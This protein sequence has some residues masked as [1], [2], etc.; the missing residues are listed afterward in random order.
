M[1]RTIITILLAAVCSMTWAQNFSYGEKANPKNETIEVDHIGVKK[2]GKYMIPV[3]GE[4]HYSRVPVSEW[5]NEIAK[6]KAGGITLLSTYVFWNHHEDVEGQ[7]SWYGK[8]NLRQFIETC[9]EEEMPVVLRIGPFCHG[10]VY[11]GG[12]PEWL[13][14]K[15]QDNPSEYKL[16]STAPGFM[17]AATRLYEEIARQ[18]YGLMWK[19]GGPIVG[20]QIENECRGPWSYYMALRDVAIKVGFDVPFM[21]RTGWP[22]LNGKEEFGKLLPL[23]G[24]YA[25]G[26][27]DRQLT[28]MPGAYKEA[29]IMKD[30]RMSRVIATETFSAEEL[31]S[32]SSPLG[33]AGVGLYPYLTCEL[34]GG[35]MPSY[36]RRINM[37]GNEAMPLAICKLGSGSNLPGYYMYH[38]GTNPNHPR[39]TMAECQNSLVTN[40][41]DMPWKSYDFQCPLGEM[42]QPHWTVWNQTRWLH[43][44]LNDWGEELAP[45]PVEGLTK[46]YSRR[47]QFIFSNTYVRILNEEGVASVTPEGM[48]WNGLTISSESVQPFAKADGQLYFITVPGKEE[49]EIDVNGAKHTL[50]PDTQLNIEGKTLN[51]LSPKR[52]ELAYV[53]DGHMHFAK[54]NAMIY[55]CDGRLVEEQ[56][57]S[58]K[59][60]IGLRKI[61]TADTPRTVKLG[62]QKV[63]E[64]PSVEDFDHA[65][66]Y[67]ITLPSSLSN[68]ADD[69]FLEINYKGDCARLYVDGELVQDNFWNGK[70]MLVRVSDIIGRDAATR[71][72]GKANEMAN[73]MTMGGSHK[74]ELRILPLKSDY[75]IYLQSEQR[76]VLDKAKDGILL[77]LTGINLLTRTRKVK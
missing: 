9:K 4:I 30:D 77:E 19:D 52:A 31:Q 57:V 50:K 60:S 53:I 49:F 7:W 29:F 42:G 16:R 44:F 36:H 10:E 40:Y 61:K 59:A 15:A 1:R 56:W 12:M 37:S 8:N 75:P 66:I 6:M 23:Y 21:T 63:A 32:G 35:M 65:E 18:V 64:Q 48:K 71:V 41:N 38:G 47:G 5:R 69:L 11:L 54:P 74:A 62:K 58:K 26:F 17:S 43:Q 51:L 45:M 73:E 68:K 14:K 39:G 55:K 28:D 22:K 67:E 13:V 34:G 2:N 25:D 24:D 33:E 3:M 70:S 46:N 76:N 20:V 72:N 27:W